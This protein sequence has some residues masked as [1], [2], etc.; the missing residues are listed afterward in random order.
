MLATGVLFF[1]T[2][3]T[4]PFAKLRQEGRPRKFAAVKIATIVVQILLTLF[5][6]KW[7]PSLHA[8]GICHGTTRRWGWNTT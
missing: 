4:I 7:A 2:L 5:L 6:L 8:A 1:D 3:T